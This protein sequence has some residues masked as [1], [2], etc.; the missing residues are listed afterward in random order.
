MHVLGTPPAFVLS[1]DQ[2]LHQ[3]QFNHP[4]TPNHQARR[5]QAH[6]LSKEP[7]KQGTTSLAYI[8]HAVE[9]SRNTRTPPHTTHRGMHAGGA[10][11]QEFH[12]QPNPPESLPSNPPSPTH[13][14]PRIPR[15]RPTPGHRKQIP[16]L[17]TPDRNPAPT[18]APNTRGD[19]TETTHRSETRAAHSTTT[20]GAW[21]ATHHARP[22]RL[23]GGESVPR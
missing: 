14:R 9:F 2:T 11:P 6:T 5:Q 22:P 7:Q 18:S 21:F 13:E 3:G 17:I 20:V 8:R 19:H 1:Q 10:L 23:L 4:P 12:S 15:K 16:S